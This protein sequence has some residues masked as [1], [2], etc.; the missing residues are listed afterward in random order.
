MRYVLDGARLPRREPFAQPLLRG[1]L[2]AREN[3]FIATVSV[4][5]RT[6]RA[7]LTNTGR[8]VELMVPG[9]EVFLRPAA[10]PDRATRFDLV[11][12]RTAHGR[13]V[14]VDTTLPNRLI[15]RAVRGGWLPGLP[16]LD[17]Y[18]ELRTEARRERSRFDLLLTAPGR[19]PLWIEVKSVTLAAGREA[20]FP[21]APTTRGTKHLAELA[22]AARAGERAAV[23]FCAQRADVDRFAPHRTMDPDFAAALVQ[24][25]RAGVAVLAC[26]CR[27]S[28]RG[29]SLGDRLPVHL[30]RR[31]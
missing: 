28:T 8:L 30:N 2:R 10:N 1:V 5:R 12:V 29:V 14:C 20:R 13:L 3:R 21:D 6:V 15:A 7:L 11:L 18:R 4:G 27:V 17:R 24:A 19:P 31:S 25:R 26:R 16:G 22:A 23:V 9:R